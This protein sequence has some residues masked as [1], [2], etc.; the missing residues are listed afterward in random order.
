MNP[1]S[2]WEAIQY[3]IDNCACRLSPLFVHDTLPR[4]PP[5]PSRQ[6]FLL[7]ISEAPP[8]SGGFWRSEVSDS[9][10]SNILRLLQSNGLKVPSN[11]DSQAAVDAFM[12]SGFFLLQ[13]IKWPLANG[14]S[15]NELSS[16]QG[17]V[18]IE[19]AALAHLRHEIDQLKPKGILA[20][21]NAAW[22]ACRRLS[23]GSALPR[24]G[25]ETVKRLALQDLILRLTDRQVPLNVML[26][27][28]NYNYNTQHEAVEDDFKGF[29]DRHCWNASLSDP[30]H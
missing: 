13:S 29:L 27:P 9:L 7:L 14:R 20:M 17:G 28:T 1:F 22:D 24:G 25:V 8:Q 30:D 12:S 2:T 23:E 10:R 21:G 6:G 5:A 19:H 26:L 3:A 15:Y 4:R 11:F 16:R 18:L